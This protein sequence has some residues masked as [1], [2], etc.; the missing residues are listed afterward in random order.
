MTAAI[1]G[2]A[3]SDLGITGRSILGLQAQAVSRAPADA[4]LP[5]KDIDDVLNADPISTPLTTADC[6]LVTDG[7]GAVAVY[8]SF[9]ITVLLSLEGLGFCEPGAAAEFIA[10]GRTRPCG[11]FPLNTSGG[12]L[13]CWHP[14]M[15]GALLLVEAVRQ[16]RGS[17]G[18]RQVHGAE[19]ALARGTGGIL[20]TR[21]AVLRGVDR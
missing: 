12:G 11:G 13:A 9:T 16:L 17:C 21:A 14:G 5:L 3:E 19:V 7:G 8:D 20:S 2:V 18:D 4:A 10:D 1:V 15:L 6:R